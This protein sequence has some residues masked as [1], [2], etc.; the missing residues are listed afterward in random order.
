MNSPSV[1]PP[2]PVP[3]TQGMTALVDPSDWRRVMRHKWCPLRKRN[4]RL[5]AQANVK[6]CGKWVRVLLHRFILGD[7]APPLIDHKDNDGLNCTR[8]NLRAA[9]MSENQHNSGPRT[10]N[11][12]KGVSWHKK[13]KKWVAQ[14]CKDGKRVH[15]GLFDDEVQ[16]AKAYDRAAVELHGQFARLNFEE[17]PS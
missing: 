5:Y 1:L 3:L 8:E 10:P 6:R 11:G 12:F 15:L 4:G 17:P 13:A 2:R 14:I 9:T 16:A 7:D